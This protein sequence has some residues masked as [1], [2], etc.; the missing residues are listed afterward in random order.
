MRAEEFLGCSWGK[1]EIISPMSAEEYLTW[2]SPVTS[3]LLAVRIANL[4]SKRDRVTRAR[5]A[6]SSREKADIVN[7]MPSTQPGSDRLPGG[8]LGL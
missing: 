4:R 6:G 1:I 2:R 7:L 3:S 8:C 5:A